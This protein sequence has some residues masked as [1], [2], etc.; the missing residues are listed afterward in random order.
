MAVRNDGHLFYTKLLLSFLL[1]QGIN[2]EHFAPL[3][4]GSA[5]QQQSD[6]DSKAGQ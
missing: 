6:Q 4:A 1:N 2:F 5:S 3:S